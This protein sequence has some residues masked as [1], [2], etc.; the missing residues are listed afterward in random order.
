LYEIAEAY[1]NINN[2]CSKAAEMY[3][4]LWDRYPNRNNAHRWAVALLGSGRVK[5][6]KEKIALA[7]KEFKAETTRLAMTT[8]A[9]VHL[10]KTK[11]HHSEY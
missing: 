8:Q 10:N 4:T 1:C 11:K 3:Q 7:D 5:E 9:F 2:D 6:A